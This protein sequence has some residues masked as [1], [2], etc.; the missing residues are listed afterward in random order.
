MSLPLLRKV[1]IPDVPRL[2][3]HLRTG[4][5]DSTI[6]LKKKMEEAKEKEI[7]EGKEIL[8]PK[9]YLISS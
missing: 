3:I 2:P 5:Q 8:I 6:T 7:L 9:I 4:L 1:N